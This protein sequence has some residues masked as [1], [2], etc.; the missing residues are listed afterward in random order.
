MQKTCSLGV[1]IGIAIDVELLKTGLDTD[2][3]TDF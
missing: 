1:D 3:D 2:S